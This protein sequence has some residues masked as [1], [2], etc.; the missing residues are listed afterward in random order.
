[1]KRLFAFSIL[2]LLF[3]TAFS[4][5]AQ[6]DAP[7]SAADRAHAQAMRM[8]KVLALSDEQ[9]KQVEQ[10]FTE[11]LLRMDELKKDTRM[12]AD[13]Q[14]DIDARK[15]QT[16]EQLKT[17]LTPEQYA[18]YKEGKAKKQQRNAAEVQK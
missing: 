17:I 18:K 4:Q 2:M 13:I 7:A 9:V 14:K 16:D 6:S 11:H 5:T 8:K 10:I 15:Q 1:M 3:T 12:A